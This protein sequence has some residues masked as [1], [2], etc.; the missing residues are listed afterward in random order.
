MNRLLLLDCYVDEP[1]SLGV[2]P[3]VSP[4][5][6]AVAGAAADAGAEVVYRTID[7]VRRSNALP[8][9]DVS[10]VVAGAGVP[11]RYLRSLPASQ[12]EVARVSKMIPGV[13]ILAG[14]ASMLAPA[15]LGFDHLAPRDGAAAA[16]DTLMGRIPSDRWRSLGEWNRWMILGA[17]VVRS[18][19]DFPQPLIAEIETYRG[20]ARYLSG[21]CS[22]CVE[23]LKGAPV[24]REPEDVIEEVAELR[25]IGVT[26]FRLGAQT[27]FVSYNAS[28]GARGPKPNPD[29]VERLLSGISELRPDVLHLD[30]A[31]PGVMADNPQEAEAI[32]TTI[33]ERC[34]SGN[35]LAL[36][37]ESADPAVI[38]A[39]NLNSTPEQVLEAIRLI[40]RIGRERGDTGLP[41]L[42][43]GLNFIVGLDGE[44]RRTLDL[45]LSFLKKVI[46]ED[47][48]LRR[49]N[50]RQVM[51]IRREFTPG[52]SHSDFVRF[53]RRVREEVDNAMLQSIVPQGTVM[54]RVYTEL[55]E[56]NRTFGRQIGT[57]AL[58][59]GF[60]YP[61]AVNVF[62][63]AMVVGWGQRSVTAV[64]YPLRLNRCPLSALE[65]LPSVGKKRAARI[66]RNRPICGV[67][68]LSKALEDSDLAGVLSAYVDFGQ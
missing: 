23:P 68:E 31:D 20:C 25:R 16:Y 26:N 24:F 15:S 2:P 55:R 22:F 43:P 61:V 59:V 60:N 48:I 38:D 66:A 1:A 47:L 56:G 9:A 11:G 49:I 35:V 12:N 34:T 45:N 41:K 67:E 62:V 40:N 42:L 4:H 6:R 57:Y 50:I 17:G 58:L 21:G 28:T 46:A 39:N 51:P 36:G 33:V 10:V 7:H 27:C 52:V 30:N 63:D 29:A 44:S 64:E 3:Y 19:P 8:E 18:H 13:K 32:L 5:V 37:M 54:K 65:S 14:P 53:K